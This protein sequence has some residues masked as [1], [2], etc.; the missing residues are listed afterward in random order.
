MSKNDP[1]KAKTT[2]VDIYADPKQIKTNQNDTKQAKTIQKE[3]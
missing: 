3:T 1:K 2:K